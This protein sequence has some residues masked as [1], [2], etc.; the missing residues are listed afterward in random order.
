MNDKYYTKETI[1]YKD[2][3]NGRPPINSM[4]YTSMNITLDELRELIKDAA[5]SFDEPIS[6]NRKRYILI[7]A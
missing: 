1:V 7:G 5:I 3:V 2:Y 6:K 4:G